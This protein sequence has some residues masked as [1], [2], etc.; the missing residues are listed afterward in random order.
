MGCVSSILHRVGGISSSLSRIDGGITSSLE[1]AE[2]GITSSL[3]YVSG[4]NSSLARTSGISC[5]M[6]LVC[7]PGVGDKYLEIEPEIIWVY[8][9]WAVDNNVYS[10]TRWNVD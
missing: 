6:G 3:Q 8:P 4:I 2:C 7:R 10:N 5:R 1:M 9:D